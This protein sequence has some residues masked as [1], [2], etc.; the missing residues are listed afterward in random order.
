[1][2]SLDTTFIRGPWDTFTRPRTRYVTLLVSLYFISEHFCL[3]HWLEVLNEDPV[4]L[5]F[6]EK[7]G[8]EK[9]T[10]WEVACGSQVLS[11]ILVTLS[12]RHDI[13]CH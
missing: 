8:V 9:V 13:H 4:F 11:Y 10:T 1:M 5:S 7:Q 3:Y 6:S 2:D 12:A